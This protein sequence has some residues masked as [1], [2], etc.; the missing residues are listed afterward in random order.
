M[1][2]T[3][4]NTPPDS[5]AGSSDPASNPASS[6]ASTSLD[7]SAL[8]AA[9]SGAVARMAG[10]ADHGNAAALFLSTLRAHYG[11]RRAILTVADQEGRDQQWFFAGL[12]DGDI[13]YFHA[14]R[15]TRESR[16]ACLIETHRTGQSYSVP[17]A[18]C[19]GH[20]G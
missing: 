19:P 17:L 20:G 15:P 5:G 2:G 10:E 1:D 13:D 8:L 7:P 6:P 9:L 4:R 12:S 18:E 14:H 11:G 3:Q 16:D